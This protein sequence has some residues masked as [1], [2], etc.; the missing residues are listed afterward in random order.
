MES[1]NFTG[2]ISNRR[3]VIAI[4]VY[5]E[6]LILEKNILRVVEFCQKNLVDDFLIVIAD[7]ASGDRT[8]EIGERLARDFFGVEYLRLEE[9]GKGLAIAT[10]WGKYDGDR[11]V[12]MDADLATDLEALPRLA[13]GDVVI[14]SRFHK[15]SAV[16]RSLVRKVFSHG[17]RLIL[18]GFLKTR[19][20]DAPCG[21]KAVS[22]AVVREILPQVQNRGFFWDTELIVLAENKGFEIVEIPVKWKESGDLMRESKVNVMSTAKDYLREVIALRK[23][24]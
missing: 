2:G 7:N 23:R 1:A 10:V 15:Q 22:P 16:E 18:R 12:F 24:L 5:N 4:P 13:T 21:F 8:G 6:E 11:Y 14:G 19:I 20:N 9:K 3:V 17:Y